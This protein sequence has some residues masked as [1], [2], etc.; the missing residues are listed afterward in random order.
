MD[1]IQYFNYTT[2][3]NMQAIK[4]KAKTWGILGGESVGKDPGTRIRT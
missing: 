4:L 3:Q 2:E 1:G